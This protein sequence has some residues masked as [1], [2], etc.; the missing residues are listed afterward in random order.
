MSTEISRR[1]VLVG[2]TLLGASAAISPLAHARMMPQDMDRDIFAAAIRELRAIVGNDWVFADEAS[3]VSYRKSF[4]PDLKGEH[5]PSG[6]VAPASV[7]EVQAI[8]K[9]ANKYKLPMWPVSTGHNMGYGMAT[10]ASSGQMILDLKRMDRI[11]DFDAELGT[12]LVE[13]GVTYQ[14]I[15]DYIEANDLPYWLDVPTV[16]PIVSMVGNTLE[17]GVGYT[18]YGDHF[19]MQCGMEVVLADGSVLKT[20]M[21]SI[22]NGNSW[23][24][25]K[26][27]YGPYLDGIFTQSN[28][29][30]VTKMGMWLM[31]KPPVYKP[32]VVRSAEMSD[33][34]RITDTIRPFRMNNLIPNGVLIMGALYQLAMFQRRTDIFD[35]EGAIPDELIKAEAKRNGLGMWNTYFALYGTE[36]T[37]AATEP[38]LR[39]AFEAAGGEVLTDAE[40]N[41][42]PWFEH[43]KTL[44]RGGMTLEEI[45]LVRWWGPQGG[46][47]AFA[48]VAPAKG[49][50]TGGQ[51]ALAKEIM[52]RHGFD[53]APAYAVGGRE[54][55]H[56]IFLMFD[57]GDDA[58]SA[59][60]NECMDEMIV[61]FGERGWAAYRSSVSTMDLVARQYGETNRDVNARLKQA[62][63]P[64][65][66]IAPGKQGIS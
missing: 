53:Y 28:F 34:A 63:D 30:V 45:G 14:Q 59:R 62:L 48:P 13:P 9:V 24:A 12:I 49:T 46:A 1:G 6:A 41:G 51:T 36:E 40:M 23:Q 39:S 25:F 5:I 31:P 58:S 60:A 61:R 22:P 54:L 52:N 57:K 65:H 7:E 17:R 10:P 3:T 20:G 27:G 15:Q 26:W 19:M 29:G 37:V 16:G 38:I 2:S 47:I 32:F 43:H 44:M 66:I 50:E 11:L 56:I 18:P 64:N 33:V 55:H 21:G 8:L 35:G 42:N 4:I